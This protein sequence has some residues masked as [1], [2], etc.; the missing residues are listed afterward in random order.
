MG[1]ENEV[2]EK[3]EE[4][5][6]KRETNLRDILTIPGSVS[7]KRKKRV[8][9]SKRRHLLDNSSLYSDQRYRTRKG[10]KNGL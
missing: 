3:R 9:E 4:K 1:R 5:K 6:R 10:S 7:L 2:I 8:E